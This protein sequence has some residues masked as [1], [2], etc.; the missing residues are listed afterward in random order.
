MIDTKIDCWLNEKLTSVR[1]LNEFGKSQQVKIK[2]NKIVSNQLVKGD[3]VVALSALAHVD[4]LRTPS[5]EGARYKR[6]TYRAQR[7]QHE[8]LTVKKKHPMESERRQVISLNEGIKLN[9]YITEKFNAR[10]LILKE[11]FE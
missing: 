7:R 6:H 4:V 2:N 5:G 8:R 9:K 1:H 3:G 10:H 11:S